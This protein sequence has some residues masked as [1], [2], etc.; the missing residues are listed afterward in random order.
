M[1]KAIVIFAG[2][3]SMRTSLANITLFS[4]RP[5]VASTTLAYTPDC[6]TPKFWEKRQYLKACHRIS[7]A[8]NLVTLRSQKSL[9]LRSSEVPDSE[10]WGSVRKV[11]SEVPDLGVGRCVRTGLATKEREAFNTGK[12]PSQFVKVT[13]NAKQV[14]N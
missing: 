12:A 11:V 5:V 2:R 3:S 10:A 9:T 14:S 4:V 1:L 13:L 6:I 8:I 7:G